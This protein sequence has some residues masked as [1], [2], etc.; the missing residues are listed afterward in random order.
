MDKE[1]IKKLWENSVLHGKSEDCDPGKTYKSAHM[2]IASIG[3]VA[4]TIE[5]SYNIARD[6]VVSEETPETPYEFAEEIS[7]GGMGIVYKGK[8][9]KL[10]REIAI[11][12]IKGESDA[13]AREKFVSES[14]VT[15]Y[16]DHPNIVPVYDLNETSREEIFLA[17]KF[18]RGTEWKDLIQPRDEQQQI[19]ARKYDEEAHLRILLN[20]CNAVAYAHSK[21]IVHNDLKPSNIMVG[22]FG[23]VLVM[24]WGI[25]VN[26]SAEDT[27][28]RG[29]RREAINA[30]L[31]T[32]NYMPWELAEGRGDNI[33]VWT[34]VYLLG[35][36]LYHILM[37]KPP[38]G[39]GMVSSLFAAVTGKLPE[40]S[41]D[42]PRE[43]QEICH[44]AMAKNIEERYHSVAHFQQSIEA[45]LQHKESIFIADN[46]QKILDSRHEVSADK[47]YRNFSQAIAGFEQALQLWKKNKDAAKGL[48]EARL[49]YATTALARGDFGLAESQL[50]SV[51]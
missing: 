48:E 33:G 35:G 17:M 46:A 20:V 39:G 6:N 42:I 8:Q 34:D 23:E 50:I 2:S 15:A 40:F 9:T 25:A 27:Q 12:K 47:L 49:Q 30:P 5:S 36:I 44:K 21:Y 13:A 10:Q 7:R 16:L 4:Q 22:E 1:S 28:R 37:K 32:P 24:D 38:H 31:G 29:L 26:I 11:K 18:V 43:L 3:P 41:A 51:T 45:Y 14:L 19:L